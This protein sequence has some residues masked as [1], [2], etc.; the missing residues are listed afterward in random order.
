MKVN[1]IKSSH[2][3]SIDKIYHI[4]D[5]HIRNLKRHKEYKQVFKRLYSYIS[6]TKTKNSIIYVAGD[7]VHSKTDLSP[8]LVSMVSDFFIALCDLCPTIVIT[9]NHDC[10]LNNSTR[11]DA[12]SPIIDAIDHPRMHYL[13]DTGLYQLCNVT[14]N[15]MSV[16]DSPTKYIMGDTFDAEYK[17]AL[18]HGAV[19]NSTTD[20]GTVLTNS[21]VKNTLFNNH[22]LV[23]LGDIHKRQILQHYAVKDNITYPTI[24]YPGSL[25]QQNHAE[26]LNHGIMVWDLPTHTSE[27]VQIDNDYGYYTLDITNNTILNWT[28]EI[29]KRPRVRIRVSNT[30]PA[31][32]KL[33]LADIKRKRKIEELTI[34]KNNLDVNTYLENKAILTNVRDVEVQNN[35]I[36]TYIGSKFPTATE[37]DIDGIRYI[38]RTINS[39]LHST[40][41]TRNITWIPKRFEFSNMFSYGEG[42]IVDMSDMT[43]MYGLFAG[44]A[45]GKSTLLDSLLFCCF[46]KCTRTTKATHILNNKKDSFKCKFIFELDGLQYRIT[47]TGLKNKDGHVRVLVDFDFIDEN[48]EFQS[49][50]G[51]ERDDTNRIIRS[52]IGTYEDFI[53]TSFSTQRNNS[54]FI[55]S[56]Q[57]ARKDLLSIFLDINIFD[58]LYAIASDQ[59]KQNATIVKEFNSYDYPTKLADANKFLDSLT[60]KLERIRDERDDSQQIINQLSSLIVTTSSNLRRVDSNLKP[61]VEITNDI[62][63]IVERNAKLDVIIKDLNIELN[64]QTNLINEKQLTIE[65]IDINEL[66]TQS[67][68]YDTAKADIAIVVS[69]LSSNKIIHNHHLENIQALHTHEYDPNCK[70]CVQNEFVKRAERS[71]I[72]IQP[73]EEKIKSL[74]LSEIEFNKILNSL[75]DINTRIREYNNIKS[76]IGTLL[77]SAEQVKSKIGIAEKDIETNLLRID[78]LNLLLSESILQEDNIKHNA[79]INKQLDELRAEFDDAQNELSDLN[80]ELNT[81]TANISVYNTNI[82]TYI[83]G[84]DKLRQLE[85]EIRLYGYY[86]DSIGRDGVPYQLIER[87]LPQLETEI[88]NIL[89]QVVDFNIVLNTDGKNVNAYIVYDVD[90]YWPIE[91]ISGMERFITSIAIRV[92]LINLTSLPRSNFLIIDEG[93][94]NLDS[95]MLNSIGLMFDYL[96]SQFQ[97][98][99]LISHIDVSRDV[100]DH[101]IEL[102][103]IDGFSKIQ[104]E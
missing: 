38:N 10:N 81:V 17:I 58:S 21:N 43:G 31:T 98:I 42:N 75:S 32:L 82:N 57:S 19:H 16:F 23:L 46:D 45:T 47:R 86:L 103:K 69:S 37:D 22:D 56:K 94:G 74:E 20:L 59:I 11:M 5:I 13:R 102:S 100:V 83:S 60:K 52:Y 66:Y 15:V 44:N 8:E 79:D 78:S 95:S 50:N 71:K 104:Y 90:N 41:S 28:D 24:A 80:N 3:T 61:H 76:D 92:A 51:E 2:I 1:T 26:I 48:G 87:A 33:L 77:H 14:F 93:L 35:L 55:D 73:I 25:I 6:T 12:I 30:E 85:T 101:I 91:L 4:A 62:K 67:H 63:L 34:Q 68:S 64:K 72:E 54:G 97:F 88:N 96:K 49:L 65:G 9:G 7:I 18:H 84:I 27:Y 53:M 39:K 70:Y 99:W 40:N 36:A 89:S 29:P